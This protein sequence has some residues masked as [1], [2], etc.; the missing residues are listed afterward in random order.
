MLQSGDELFSRED[1]IAL[2]DAFASE[3]KTLMVNPGAHAAI[4]PFMFGLNEQF[5]LRHLAA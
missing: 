3:E 5:F 4:P 2:Y 1:G